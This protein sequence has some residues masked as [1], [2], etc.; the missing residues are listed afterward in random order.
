LYKLFSKEASEF[1]DKNEKAF[2]EYHMK[3]HYTDGYGDI[4]RLLKMYEFKHR[5]KDFDEDS[6]IT[7][8]FG[9]K[10]DFIKGLA[11][12]SLN[13]LNKVELKN[14]PYNYSKDLPNISSFLNNIKGTLNFF[15]MYG[16]DCPIQPL[17]MSS[18]GIFKRTSEEIFVNSFLIE[19]DDM[20][21]LFSLCS[22]VKRIAFVNCAI[23]SKRFELSKEPE[24]H[25][26]EFVYF[27]DCE[28][29]DQILGLLDAMSKT[30]IRKSLKYIRLAMLS[31]SNRQRIQD[32]VEEGKFDAQV[33]C[34]W[35]LPIA[36]KDK[37]SNYF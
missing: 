10:K 32:A 13:D 11:E 23:N 26:E 36:K 30:S 25:I 28:K 8:Y 17:M 14:V 4:C 1:W 3:T 31:K 21:G 7:I 35:Y 18:Q 24:Y 33:D 19:K 37:K 29:V 20:A 12:I 9:E 22:C 27:D 15:S 34:S 16:K 6:T 5:L 2:K